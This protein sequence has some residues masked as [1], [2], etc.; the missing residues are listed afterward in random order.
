MSLPTLAA[1]KAEACGPGGGCSDANTS[2]SV[3]T[4]GCVLSSP[5]RVRAKHTQAHTEC[6]AIRAKHT[7]HTPAHRGWGGGGAW[8]RVGWEVGG[9]SRAALC[10]AR[11]YTRMHTRAHAARHAHTHACTHAH[12]RH[13]THIHTHA[14]PRTCGPHAGAGVAAGRPGAQEGAIHPSIHADTHLLAASFRSLLTCRR[15]AIKNLHYRHI[16]MYICYVYCLLLLLL[17]R[18][19]LT[20]RRC[21]C[22]SWS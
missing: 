16:D 5:A 11:T 1:E 7:R 10:A 20:P 8:G 4:L 19:P 9:R 2:A 6:R 17:P 22:G 15:C 14:R 3:A 21:A 13:A 18:L 12:T